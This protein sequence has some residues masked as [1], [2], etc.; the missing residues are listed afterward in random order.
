MHPQPWNRLLAWVIDWICILAWAALLAAVGIPLRL[1]GITDGLTFVALNIIATLVLVVPV[2]LTLAGLES[3]AR[4]ASI[5]K[6]SRHLLVMNSR[7]GLRL[8]FRRAL[9]RNT[10]KVAAP[11]TIGHAAVYGIVA[12]SADGSVPPSIWAGTAFAYVLPAAYVASLFFG[13]G[14]TPYDRISGTTVILGP[15]AKTS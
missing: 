5:G 12:S 7:T 14:R 11:W 10:M 2:T 4:Q 6:H 1:A 3:S 13:T 9:V 8:S 15:G